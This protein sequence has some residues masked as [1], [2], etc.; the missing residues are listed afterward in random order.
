ML[1][2]VGTEKCSHYIIRTRLTIPG[3]PH[4]SSE[5]F[6]GLTAYEEKEGARKRDGVDHNKGSRFDQI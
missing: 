2:D 3:M 4:S 5:K 6:H 1:W